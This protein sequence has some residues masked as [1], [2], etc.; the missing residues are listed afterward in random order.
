MRV[1]E[2]VLATRSSTAV[3]VDMVSLDRFRWAG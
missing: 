2:L 3:V 1:I